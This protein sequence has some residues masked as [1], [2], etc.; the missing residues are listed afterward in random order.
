[1]V[2]AKPCLNSTHEQGHVGALPATVGVQFIEHDE[3][4]AKAGLQHLPVPGILPRH[5]QLE[6][7]EVRQ[8]DV[9]LGGADRFALSPGILAGV[10]GEAGP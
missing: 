5:Q 1:M 8:Q 2:R 9:G 3:I 7:D 10:A 6:H 4:Q